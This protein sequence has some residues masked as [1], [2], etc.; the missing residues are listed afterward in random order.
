MRAVTAPYREAIAH[1]PPGA[2][3]VLNDVNWDDY[4]R[5]LEELSDRAGMR[6]SYDD[7][8]LRVMSPSAEHE[9][10]KELVLRLAQVCADELGLP[11]E[12][13]GSTT[14]KRR[15]MR[16]A[17]EPDTC[18]YVTN[19]HRII[20]RTTIDLET[21]PP[22]DV[23]VEIDLSHEAPAKP[24]IYAALGVPEIWRYDGSH[25]AM[26]R[27]EEGAYQICAGSRFLP[28]ITAALL[29]E[30]LELSARRGQTEALRV[31]RKRIRSST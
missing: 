30:L 19:A 12:T 20:G 9:A 5:L 11:L 3:L 2:L 23:V 8:R 16:K 6:I 14:W 1:L 15:G 27:L 4:E 28:A 13:R 29:T 25:A 26:F 31:F 21:D 17:A 7:G 18:F 22:P 24:A 10:Y